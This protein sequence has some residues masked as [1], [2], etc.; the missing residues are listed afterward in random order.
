MNITERDAKKLTLE[1]LRGLVDWCDNQP[2]S[3]WRPHPRDLTVVQILA[4]YHMA[5]DAGY[6]GMIEWW[7]DEQRAALKA[8][9]FVQSRKFR[10]MVVVA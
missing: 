7:E 2:E 4:L 10:A 5:N 1:D 8:W 6:Y 3:F 9:R